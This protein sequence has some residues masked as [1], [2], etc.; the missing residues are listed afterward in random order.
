MR[1]KDSLKDAS[2]EAGRLEVAT[3]GVHGALEK[4]QQRFMCCSRTNITYMYFKLHLA[5]TVAPP[6]RCIAEISLAKSADE[7]ARDERKDRGGGGLKVT[8]PTLS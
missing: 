8:R 7:G 1:A 2:T 4:K 6:P 3:R 5:L